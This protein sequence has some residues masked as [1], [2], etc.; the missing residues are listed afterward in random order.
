MASQETSSPVS[1]CVPPVKKPRRGTTPR[2]VSRCLSAT[3]AADG[4]DVDAELLGDL[5]HGQGPQGLRAV[6]EIVALGVHHD[7]DDA[8]ERLTALLDG[9]DEPGRVREVLRRNSLVG[10]SASFRG[11]AWRIPG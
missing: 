3:G 1:V 7:A 10:F 4:G 2:G 9:I 11:R 5:G 6:I 8:Q